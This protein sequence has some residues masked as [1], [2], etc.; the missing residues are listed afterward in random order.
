MVKPLRILTFWL[1]KIEVQSAQKCPCGGR[2]PED[3][4]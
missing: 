2:F 4:P 3:R 1:N